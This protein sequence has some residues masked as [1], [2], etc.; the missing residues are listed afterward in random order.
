MKQSHSDDR[1]RR[2]QDA[3]RESVM[4]MSHYEDEYDDSLAESL[5]EEFG[6][7]VAGAV[8]TGDQF[9]R[10]LREQLLT[11]SR[12]ACTR[13]TTFLTV[14]TRETESL[15]TAE[16]TITALGSALETLDARSLESWSPVELADSYEQLLTAEDRCEELVSERQT[17]LHSHGLPGPMPIDSDLDLTEYLYQSLSV[18]HP[19]LADLA[20][21]ADTLRGERQRVE[22]AMQACETHLSHYS[23]P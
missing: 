5:A 1:L 18:T 12:E 3:Y 9:T 6:P 4:S 15:Q 21:L 14:L 13:R 8:L 16:E 23:S 19:V 22:R 2:V 17:T 11:A 7:E 10:S 20:D